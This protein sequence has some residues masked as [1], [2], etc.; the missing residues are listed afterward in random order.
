[1]RVVRDA[2]AAQGFDVF[3]NAATPADP[4]WDGW[5]RRVLAQCKC[6]VVLWSTASV[7]SNKVRHEVA[8]AAEQGK[9]IPVRLEQLNP[10]QSQNGL[11][12]TNWTGDL[13]HPQWQ[14]L[15]RQI[16]AQLA[17]APWIQH[18]IGGL[19]EEL[20][21]ERARNASS[22]AHAKSLGEELAK[23]LEGQIIL[24]MERDA[25][26]DEIAALQARLEEAAK[27]R[28]KLEERV[29]AVERRASRAEELRNETQRLLEEERRQWAA[30]RVQA[31]ADLR[32]A[33]AEAAQARV[34]LEEAENGRWD[35]KSRVMQ[36]EDGIRQRDT[37]IAVLLAD[38]KGRDDSIAEQDTRIGQLRTQVEER[39]SEIVRLRA[40]IAELERWLPWSRA[41]ALLGVLGVVALSLFTA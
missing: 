32:A 5:V 7:Q 39:D 38:I 35:L 23:E 20:A 29:G 17:L 41:A 3:R 11:D 25:A 33:R 18:L 30:E 26:R 37:R 9:L 6:V 10:W 15:L 36:L 19:N 14:E 16:E 4:E 12:L 34:Q 31:Q 1:V 22:V 21:G 13:G 8:L 27:V 2:L 40:R 24:R 28:F